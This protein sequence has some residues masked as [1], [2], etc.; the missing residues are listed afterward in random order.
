M[1]EAEAVIALPPIFA[2]L[3]VDAMVRSCRGRVGLGGPPA[4]PRTPGCD[5]GLFAPVAF[6]FDY[7]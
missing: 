7:D 4:L 6:G 1:A 5:G 2:E 3:L